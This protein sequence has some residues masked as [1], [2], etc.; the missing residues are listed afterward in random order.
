MDRTPIANT[1]ILGGSRPEPFSRD[2]LVDELRQAHSV[3]GLRGRA[4]EGFQMLADD[5]MEHGVLGVS[6]AIH[7]LGA[8][9]PPPYR[10][11]S[12]APMPTD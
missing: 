8:R 2:V 4:E 7:G 3:A 10:G 9:H 1:T 5:L 12:G 6:R 11:L